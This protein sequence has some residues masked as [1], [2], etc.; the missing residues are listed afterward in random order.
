MKKTTL[1]LGMAI[2]AL[3]SVSFVMA[4]PFA[5][6]AETKTALREAVENN[7][8]DSWKEI[9]ESELTKENFNELVLHREKQAEFRTA[10]NEAR[11]SGD[12]ETIQS[13][14]AQMDENRPEGMPSRMG[15][16]E[17][18]FRNKMEGKCPFSE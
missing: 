15:N 14:R 9:R 1:I 4:M 2:L 16:H 7:D 5:K 17:K 10:M 18:G 12:F 8:F 11:E 13:L 6:N 3:L